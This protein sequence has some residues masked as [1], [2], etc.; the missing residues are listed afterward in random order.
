VSN[1]AVGEV[2][3]L[4]GVDQYHIGT[5]IGKMVSPK[6]EVLDVQEHITQQK[7]RENP[8]EHCLAEDWLDTKPVF[9]V[10][11]GGLQPGLIPQIIDLLGT[12]IML[13]LGGGVHGHPKGSHAGAIAMRAA[14][15]AKLEGK[16]LEE[17][18]ASCKALQQAM[19]YWGYTRPR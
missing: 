10:A 18:S 13:Q 14:L 5:H 2:V 7:V 11:S 9:P 1:L 3:S 17:A 6:H 15:E 4:L 12:E 8:V 19:D 16:S